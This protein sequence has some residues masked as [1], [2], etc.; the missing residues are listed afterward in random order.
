MS[1]VGQVW[2]VEGKKAS[3]GER[4][5]SLCVVQ[6]ITAC[7][8]QAFLFRGDSEMAQ[9][10]ERL[11]VSL[12]LAASALIIPIKRLLSFKVLFSYETY[13]LLS[14]KVAST[15]SQPS[16]CQTHGILTKSASAP[17]VKTSSCRADSTGRLQAEFQGGLSWRFSCGV[18]SWAL[19][20][21]GRWVEGKE[22]EEKGE[23]MPN[24]GA[25]V[26]PKLHSR[27][28]FSSC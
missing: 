21:V 12:S 1:S 24:A 15:D 18:R 28:V 6:R 25:F 27:G 7:S 17:W 26:H 14:G 13:L 2:S 4:C 16:L 9:V 10:R 20:R 3:F 22:K 19:C 5:M 11:K 8:V 23:R